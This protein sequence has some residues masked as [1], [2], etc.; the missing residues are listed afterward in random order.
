MEEDGQTILVRELV[1]TTGHLSHLD[2]GTCVELVVVETLRRKLQQGR[3]GS[4]VVH[5]LCYLNIG[6]KERNPLIIITRKVSIIL[7]ITC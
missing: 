5:K 3:V 7:V 4:V 1:P 6:R 2:V